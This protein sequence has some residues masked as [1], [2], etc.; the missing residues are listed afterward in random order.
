MLFV[1]TLARY[2]GR[3]AD[4]LLTLN[5]TVGSTIYRRSAFTDAMLERD[6]TTEA[7]YYTDDTS[8]REVDATT[9]PSSAQ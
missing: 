8:L 9:S 7:K 3:L 5:S 6:G 1:N 4:C 2:S